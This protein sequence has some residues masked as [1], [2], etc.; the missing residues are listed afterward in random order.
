MIFV[1]TTE[2]QSASVMK[3]ILKWTPISLS[4]QRNLDMLCRKKDKFYM[5]LLPVAIHAL[6]APGF[7]HFTS[8][9]N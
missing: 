8:I 6:K 9:E 4:H 2:G 7:L 3:L 1:L 5:W